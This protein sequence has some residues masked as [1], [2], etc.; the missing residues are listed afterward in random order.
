MPVLDKN[1]KH[2]TLAEIKEKLKENPNDKELLELKRMMENFE[3]SFAPLQK[4]LVLFSERF[5]ASLG[6]F[7]KETNAAIFGIG[8]FKPQFQSILLGQE[9]IKSQLKFLDVVNSFTI[10]NHALLG[11]QRMAEDINRLTEPMRLLGQTVA[12]L[13]TP[14]LFNQLT[15]MKTNWVVPGYVPSPRVFKTEGAYTN[16]IAKEEKIL[17]EE[18]QKLELIEPEIEELP[19]YYYRQT[20]TLIIQV[21][22]LAAITF[23]TKRGNT[24]VEKFFES[25]LD[26]LEEKGQIVGEFKKVFISKKELVEKLVSKGVVE[27]TEDWIKTTRSSIVNHKIPSFLE[28]DI[29]ISEYDR[30][31]GGYHF[32]IR[33]KTYLP[34]LH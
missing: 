2:L 14:N 10:P 26:L 15:E 11:L 24:N 13:Q 12:M 1:T 27:P 7:N 23:Y 31:A 30:N 4:D 17:T 21:T 19:Y 9:L 20:K 29:L 33:I 18:L 5:T 25:L 8:A 32:Q 34:K 6:I 22:H 3:K 28:N 16:Q